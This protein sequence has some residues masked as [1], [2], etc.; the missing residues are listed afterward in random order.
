MKIK[1]GDTV[2]VIAGKNAGKIGKVVQ[3]L[4][5]DDKVVVEGINK[6]TKH[7]KS[8]RRGEKGQKFE[9]DAPIHVSNVM[10][11]EV[12]SGKPS[13]VGYKMLENGEKVRI[14]KKSGEAI[15]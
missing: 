12:K 4:P 14:S 13:R 10:V 1:K 7:M 9:F 5:A 8:Q 2:K 6:V 3:V 15:D 11:V